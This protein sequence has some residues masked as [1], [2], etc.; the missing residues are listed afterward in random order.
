MYSIDPKIK[1]Y[2]VINEYILDCS[3][4]VNTIIIELD[5]HYNVLQKNKE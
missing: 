4:D 5:Y 2:K 3:N 1:N